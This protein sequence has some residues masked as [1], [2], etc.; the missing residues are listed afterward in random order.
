[1]VRNGRQNFSAIRGS[2]SLSAKI[3]SNGEAVQTNVDAR[4][5]RNASEPTVL[6]LFDF[7]IVTE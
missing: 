6:D 5:R 3:F 2:G 4:I 1:M 7:R